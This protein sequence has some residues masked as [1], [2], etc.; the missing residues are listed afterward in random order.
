MIF[1]PER[2]PARIVEL[3]P[4]HLYLNL[5]RRLRNQPVDSKSLDR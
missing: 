4:A 5:L 1:N 2:T 3:Y